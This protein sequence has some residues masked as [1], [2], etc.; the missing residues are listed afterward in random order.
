MGYI[1]ASTHMKRHR[2]PPISC[3]PTMFI[4]WLVIVLV[5]IIPPLRGAFSASPPALTTQPSPTVTP[6]ILKTKLQEVEATAGLDEAVKGKLTELYR[7]A[8]SQLETSRS[9]NAAAQAFIQARETASAEAKAVR[10]KL[11]RAERTEPEV[12]LSVSEKTPLPEVEQQL[13]KEKANLAAVEAKLAELEEHL[14]VQA[15]RPTVAQQRLTE[16]RQR[17]EELAAALKLSPPADELP[18][19]T[20][21]KRWVVETQRLS[22]S[23]EMRM[24]D[25]ELLSQPMRLDL[26]K[27]QRDETARSVQRI[28]TRVN[29]LAEMV[30][31]RRRAE[32]ER[33]QKEAEA[34]M[35]EA[36][37]KHPLVQKLAAQNAAL[38]EELGA[39][40][41]DLDRVTADREVASKEVKRI[42]EAFRGTKQ[43]LEIAGLSQALG[44]V[45]LEQRRVLPDLRRLRQ[46]ARS[47]D[48]TIAHAGLRQIRHNEERRRLRSIGTYVD[49]LVADL[50]GAEAARIRG[51]LEELAKS[52]RDLLDKAIALDEAYLRILGELDAIQRQLLD[53]VAAYD[54]LLTEMMLWIRNASLPTLAELR[55]MPAQV[56][57]L[58]SPRLWR[59]TGKLLVAREMQVPIL[60]M[61]MTLCGLLLWNA[62]RLR[63][64][65]QAPAKN[66]GRPR[67]D[68]FVFTFQA[69]VVSLLLAAPWPLMLVGLG[70]QLQL[71]PGPTEFSKAISFG[72]IRIASFFL[73]LRWFQVL[74][75]PGGLAATHFRWPESSLQI[76]RRG[77]GRL[78]L[79]FLPAGFVATAIIRLESA[80]LGGS[81][82]RLALIVV[83]LTLAVFLYRLFDPERGALRLFLAQHP[84][85]MLARLR[86][87]WLALT[88]AIPLALAGLSL[89]GYLY[90]SIAL[91]SRF[92]RTLLLIL[93]LVMSHQLAMRWLLLI[94]RRIAFQAAL[95]RREAA[96]AA[97]AESKEATVPGSEALPLQVEESEVNLIALSQESQELLNTAVVIVGLIGVW[98]IWSEVLPAFG[99]LN[100][101]TLWYQTAIVSGQEK[102]LPITLADVVLGLL[103]AV[104][105]IVAAKRF[106]AFL[107]IVLLHRLDLTAGSRYAVTTLSRYLIVAIGVGWVVNTMG[108]SWS[109]IQWLVAALGVGI[110]FGLQEIVANFVSGLILLFERPVRVG[111]IVTVGDVSGVVTRIRIRATT[112]RTWERKELLVPNKQFITERLLNWSLSDQTTRILVPVGVAYGS[113]VQKAMSLMAEA[114][115]ENERILTD[116]SPF[117]T[118][119]GFGDN[120]LTLN[121]RCYIGSIE[122][123]LTTTSALHEAINR[124]FNDAGI[125]IAFPQRDVHF[126]TSHPLDIRIRRTERIA[127]R[128]E[129]TKV[130][131]AGIQ[132]QGD[133]SKQVT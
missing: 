82:G 67:S 91:T 66:L 75:E 35:L 84:T 6:D 15:E 47:R 61:T 28:S 77:L 42:T 122:Y 87:L 92:I 131:K 116:P 102:L 48:Q 32:A 71:S 59:D 49:G 127:E 3:V 93:G 73:Y 112:I 107:E 5:T 81:L 125:V 72:M 98:L 115:V 65:L 105:T 120:A 121:L 68:R 17:Q 50:P 63:Q 58:A 21:A 126:D 132:E 40:A 118:F 14:A 43:K 13:L 10:Q 33:A 103:I 46:Q 97:A 11:E 104:V 25:Q 26:L 51:A 30:N 52:R 54:E 78:M 124:K 7:K 55:A 22:L 37:G 79:T 1:P 69:L 20:E 83:A 94:R 57:W 29:L 100:R 80:T 39:L 38:S 90:T 4:C 86:Y 31:Q 113:D 36:I 8:L 119:E 27:A 108:G 56:S 123:R 76:L 114:A 12:K 16:A 128:I 45:L 23:Q 41:A 117:V 133:Q 34:A 70:W 88:V 74:C 19:L 130:V 111:D 60:T 9:Y 2:I 89:A 129:K 106:P 101:V 53:T 96:R 64:V 95:Q 18:L 110:G 85:S 62:K 109:Q 99:V 44:Q 24:L